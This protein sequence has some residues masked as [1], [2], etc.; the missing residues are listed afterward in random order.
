MHE[1]IYSKQYLN[2]NYS[3]KFPII[4]ETNIFRLRKSQRNCNEL[5]AF[6][7]QTPLIK[8]I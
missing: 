8:N 6:R 4:N 2:I 7:I 3:F 5:I 1:K